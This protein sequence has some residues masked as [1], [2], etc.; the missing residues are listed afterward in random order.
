MKKIIVIKSIFIVALAAVSVVIFNGFTNFN[1]KPSGDNIKE[2]IQG[3]E[4]QMQ[5][6]E[7]AYNLAY[8]NASISGNEEDYKTLEEAKI[9]LNIFYADK[10]NFNTI[11]NFI[12]YNLNIKHINIDANY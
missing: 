3:Y 5:E 1:P 4:V 12:K 11:S 6:L 10:G 2:F 7:K 8:F 9:T